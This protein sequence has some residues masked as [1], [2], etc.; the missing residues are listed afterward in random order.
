MS[1]S[2]I[3]FLR[4]G[5]TNRNQTLN[6]DKYNIKAKKISKK[7][8][9]IIKE[10]FIVQPIIFFSSPEERCI[11]TLNLLKK[12]LIKRGITN[13]IKIKINKNL[14][15]WNKNGSETRQASKD[16]AL[17]YGNKLKN[18]FKSQYNS[19]IIYCTHSSILPSIIEG[20]ND[21]NPGYLD[22]GA[23][24]Y[25]NVKNKNFNIKNY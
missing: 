15:R 13:E 19:V 14:I 1:N 8:F 22:E 21:K 20:I 11:N 5:D 16:R 6:Y 3:I 4:H 9:T 2:H 18:F 17:K 12:Y 24:F 23:M 25:Y 10:N 7:I